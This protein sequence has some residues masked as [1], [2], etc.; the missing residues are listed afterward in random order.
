MSLKTSVRSWMVG[1]TVQFAG[2]GVQ[3]KVL[4]VKLPIIGDGLQEVGGFVSKLRSSIAGSISSPS[5]LIGTN[6]VN[7]LR[8]ILFNTL[9]GI[10]NG[11]L[12][13]RNGDGLINLNDVGVVSSAT[14]VQY[15]LRLGGS[16]AVPANLDFDLSLPGLGL[17]L[18]NA[19]IS[20]AS[21]F[22]FDVSVGVDKSKGAYFKLA[23]TKTDD[24]KLSV[25]ASLSQATLTGK[26]GFLQLAV[27]NQN[28][29]VSGNFN[30]DLQVPGSG[31]FYLSDLSSVADIGINASFNGAVD[32]DLGLEASFGGSAK[33]PRLR[34]GLSLDWAFANASTTSADFGGAPSL[35]YKTVQ[36]GLGSFLRDFLGQIVGEVQKTLKPIQPILDVLTAPIPVISDLAG[37]TTLVDVAR[38]FG[39]A[40]V[41]D[42]IDAV[43]DINDLAN[44]ISG[45]GTG[46]LWIDLGEFSVDGRAARTASQLGNLMPKNAQAI[47]YTA[48]RNQINAAAPA[49]MKTAFN[50]STA[51]NGGGFKFPILENPSS[52]MALLLGRDITLFGYDMPELGMEFVYSQFFPIIGPLG[53]R[54]TGTI[55]A[56][57]D[58]AFGF[59]T[60]GLRQ[61]A[62]SDFSNPAKIFDGF[63]VSD[64]KSVDG[65]GPDVP[66]ITLYGSLTAAAELNVVVARAGVGGGVFVDVF[67]NLH[68]IDGDGKIRAREFQENFSLGPIHIFDVSGAFT[69]KLF[70]YV[71]IGFPTPF[72]FVTLLNEEL[73]LAEVTLLDF[74]IPRP[75]STQPPL[76]TVANGVLSLSTSE[77]NDDFVILPG[78][79]ANQVRVESQGRSELYDGVTSLSFDG[80]GGDDKVTINPAIRL[81]ATLQGG[82]GR[83][84]LKSGG[85]VSTLL[86]GDDD[87]RL[88]AG[89]GR[90]AARGGKGRDEIT[91]GV[92]TD[93]L[94]GDEGDDTISG[95]GSGD[96]IDGGDGT[97]S[98]SGDDGNDRI[99][100]GLGDDRIF[101]GR[102]NDIL[103]GN[104]GND[105][106]VG[107][108]GNDQLI[109]GVGDDYLDGE[110]GDDVLVGDVATITVCNRFISSG[111]RFCWHWGRRDSW[112]LG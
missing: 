82:T 4:S 75:T 54:I 112:W 44:K 104:E 50:T 58:F 96:I 12:G 36:L 61:F 109:G 93:T 70:A 66:E 108:E 100:G 95:G 7:N 87:D 62:A 78:A 10:D 27:T 2:S 101:G 28:S 23:P 90:V 84:I 105:Q 48:I 18:D 41:A 83:D 111:K 42:F 79:N 53:A 35:K 14:S 13:D 99:S 5:A 51:V 92:A 31:F 26:L 52:A 74:S 91:G 107:E 11:F 63:F 1:W 89:P 110:T 15:D 20:L 86:G 69:G 98:L 22:S 47:N 73:T 68:D 88:I 24:L 30:V 55:G 67:F 65:T 38:L 72:G 57:A 80:K 97:D 37:P 16:I 103:S 43:A 59:D 77:G 71:K 81:P 25:S 33:F 40:K 3:S 76:A 94:S 17:S 19:K 60:F 6:A 34:T 9:S 102:D 64:T 39:Y 56:K 49:E 46:E 8:N 45:V 85:G 21:S 29:I 32:V 106:L